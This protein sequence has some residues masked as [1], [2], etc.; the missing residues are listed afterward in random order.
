M[1]SEA[2]EATLHRAFTVQCCFMSIKTTFTQDFSSVMLFGA[3]QTTLHSVL[4]C[5]VLSQEY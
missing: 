3:S 1:L 2:S 5:A 4:T